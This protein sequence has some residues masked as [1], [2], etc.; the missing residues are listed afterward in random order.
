MYGIGMGLDGYLWVVKKFI[1]ES[2][3]CKMAI[4]QISQRMPIFRVGKN[5]SI[6]DK[7]ESGTIS[8]L[9]LLVLIFGTLF[10]LSTIVQSFSSLPS[11]QSFLRSHRLSIPTQTPVWRNGIVASQRLRGNIIETRNKINCQTDPVEAQTL[12]QS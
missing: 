9:P 2:E 1:R 6:K 11:A 5:T 4:I 8:L 3:K 7:V 10:D 12:S